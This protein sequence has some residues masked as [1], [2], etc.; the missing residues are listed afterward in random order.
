MAPKTMALGRMAGQT[1]PATSV[2]EA[3]RRALSTDCAVIDRLRPTERLLFAG[4]SVCVGTFACRADDP[5]YHDESPSTA[6][7]IVFARTAVWIRH[8]RG[9]RF[10]ADPTVVTFHNR[11]R[12]YRRW[13]IA[14]ESDRC[15]W[16]AYADDVVANAMEERHR[17]RGRHPEWF[18]A[19]F[20]FAASEVYARQRRLFER[21]AAG[22][23]DAAEVE[24]QAALLLDRAL[25]AVQPTLPGSLGRDIDAIHHARATIAAAPT[26]PVSLRML[27]RR[28]DMTPFTFCRAFSRVSGE[29]MTSYRLRL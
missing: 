7:C 9:D 26:A 3:T 24:E 5:E 21:V 25:G 23:A 14:D 20:A 1:P 16:I 29:T 15:D 6:H 18:P 11:G 19:D 2:S 13:R 8:E 22:E 27:A 28:A 4:D 17:P 12:V 10:V